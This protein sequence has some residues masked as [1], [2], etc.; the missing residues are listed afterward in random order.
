MKSM[1]GVS[2]IA[3]SGLLISW[4][5]HFIPLHGMLMNYTPSGQL[6]EKL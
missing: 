4:L 2:Y 1:F 6:K 5:Y 3:L